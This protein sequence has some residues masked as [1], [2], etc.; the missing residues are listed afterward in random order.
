[1][2][3]KID[4]ENWNRNKQYEWFKN[5]SNSCYGIDSKIDV[6]NLV[7]YCKENGKSFFICMMY[8]VMKSLN[9]IDQ[10][11]MRYE[12]GEAYLYSDINPAYTVMTKSGDF[13]NVRH[14]N[15]SK[16]SQFYEKAKNEIEKVKNQ[17]K[18]NDENYN[19]EKCYNEYYITSI[20]WIS[21]T[22]F[23]HPIPDDKANASIPR[24]CWDKYQENG[25]K[26][27]L[28]L[29]ITV[30]HMFVDGFP[31]SQAFIRIQEMIYDIKSILK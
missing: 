7:Q 8:V 6:T 12:D 28:I 11:R 17:I 5:F 26:Y 3:K 30:S 16:F 20:P 21:V 10:M 18:L 19:P 23:C 29:N 25:G 27:E 22:S 2:K 9:S 14:R 4:I 1:M 24:I 31:L 13:E 15:Y